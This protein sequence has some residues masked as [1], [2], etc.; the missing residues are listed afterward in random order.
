M[1]EDEYTPDKISPENETQERGFEDRESTPRDNDF[2][3]IKQ[4]IDDEIGGELQELDLLLKEAKEFDIGLEDERREL[5]NIREEVE[6]LK[7]MV[8]TALIDFLE[9]QDSLEELSDEKKKE[10]FSM[11]GSLEVKY[12][13]LKEREIST[14]EIKQQIDYLLKFSDSDLE[15]Q[16]ETKVKL[17][18]TYSKVIHSPMDALKLAA[19]YNIHPD[20]DLIEKI[21]RLAVVSE[22]YEIIEER[23][24]FDSEEVVIQEFG[25]F[26]DEREDLE[27]TD[28]Q[29]RILAET[30]LLKLNRSS[31][32]EV[33]Q[34]AT[35]EI[36]FEPAP[37]EDVAF[38]FE[39]Y[40]ESFDKKEDFP[41]DEEPV[42]V[43]RRELEEE[44]L[45]DNISSDQTPDEFGR[46]KIKLYQ[47]TRESLG[48][49]YDEVSDDEAK[50]TIEHWMK[51]NKSS[52]DDSWRNSG[53]PDLQREHLPALY[54]ELSESSDWPDEGEELLKYYIS[55]ADQVLERL[56][57]TSEWSDEDWSEEESVRDKIVKPFLDII[58]EKEEESYR[59]FFEEKI[60][61]K[62]IERLSQIFPDLK[63]DL[64]D[65][66]DDFG[67]VYQ[68]KLSSPRKDVLFKS[69]N[70][71]EYSSGTRT[72]KIKRGV[73]GSRT[74]T[75]ELIHA[76]SQGGS[77]KAI[78]MDDEGERT[79]LSDGLTEAV[80][81]SCTQLVAG[82]HSYH[83]EI[84]ALNELRFWEF[85]SPE[86]REYDRPEAMKN[87][88]LSLGF[89]VKALFN[90]KKSL[91]EALKDKGFDEEDKR[92][93]LKVARKLF[94]LH[95]VKRI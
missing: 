35:E 80:V 61:P 65:R 39:P 12:S 66:S 1:T 36:E 59:D 22:P 5:E 14:L 86:L 43:V 69:E 94:D 47:S 30:A 19:E 77:E 13:D 15:L 8:K 74:P 45:L 51:K 64:A 40:L 93:F 91:E 73:T 46:M 88:N 18:E 76:L 57:N 60:E 24:D 6:R 95:E 54:R 67:D 29:K 23:F 70:S 9:N 7:E 58:F 63:Q 37:L 52:K 32:P 41:F 31:N 78:F 82:D 55:V 75:H 87:E 3:E 85:S 21:K 83:R 25:K 90:E 48:W 2:S 53:M 89:F 10:V 72:I 71:G 81:D 4:T 33:Y 84:G 17:F 20:K 62:T 16:E 56:E 34:E 27:L 44:D 50:K 92:L 68:I 28:K 42:E 38:D 11:M 49:S 26:Y 79:P